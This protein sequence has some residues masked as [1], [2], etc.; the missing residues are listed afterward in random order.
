MQRKKLIFIG[1][2][3]GGGYRGADGR[4][5][6]F[7]TGLLLERLAEHYDRVSWCASEEREPKASLAF[8][9]PDNVEFI[10]Y[11]KIYSTLRS[12]AHI[13]E[14]K[15]TYRRILSEPGD[16]FIRGMLPASP[17]LYAACRK[18]GARP[19]HWLVGNPV[20]LLKS[21]RRD[22]YL[23]DSLA[24]FY[25]K[26]WER[27]VKRGIRKTKGAFLCFGQELYDRVEGFERYNYVAA[28]LVDA[29]FYQRDDTCQGATIRVLFV[30]FI[31][32]EKGVQYLVEALPK[33][34]TTRPVELVCVG[35]AGGRYASYVDG[36]KATIA[37]HS[38]E[39]RV[40]MLGY[41]NKEAIQE[42][43]RAA[44][45]FVL[46]T[47]SEGAPYVIAESRAQSLPT[48]A[49]RVGGIPTSITD[50][51]DGILVPSK[52]SDAI[53]SA[54]DRVISDGD[55][56]RSMIKEGYKSA[57]AMTFDLF[58]DKIVAILDKLNERV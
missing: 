26:S 40:K 11:P 21:H 19:L 56:R 20:A 33:L 15:A 38:L 55:L 53:A 52:N 36:I 12:Y 48:I 43:M 10:P 3:G 42:Q 37:K 2:G 14:Y 22:G 5:T 1:S 17:A 29:D 27:G 45:I 51:V 46:P 8:R 24:M 4:Y 39:S 54:I 58:A 57:R 6:H 18:I 50:G 49:T 16:V 31:R 25:A 32:P 30:G 28:P 44:D 41:M 13:G 23:K 7:S 35:D 34:K 9:V 47:L